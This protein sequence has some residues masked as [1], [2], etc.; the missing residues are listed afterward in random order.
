MRVVP[1]TQARSKSATNPNQHDVRTLYWYLLSR[2]GTPLDRWL[3]V[4]PLVQSAEIDLRGS[5]GGWLV[6]VVG[7]ESSSK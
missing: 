6:R 3:E 4:E 5:L 1:R 2:T 7:D